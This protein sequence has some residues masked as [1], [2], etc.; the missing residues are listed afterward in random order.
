MIERCPIEHTLDVIS[1]KWKP[2]IIYY[3]LA[4]T[5][6]F[7]ELQRCIPQ[8]NRRMLTKHLREL[9]ADGIVHREVYKQVPPKVEYSLT[10]K[11]HTLRPVMEMMLAWGESHAAE[12]ETTG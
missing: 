5:R 7:G 10:E 4:E 3:L 8:V 2:L 11:G 6:R 9:E 12:Q 1:G